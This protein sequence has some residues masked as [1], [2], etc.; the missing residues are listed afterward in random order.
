MKMRA[1][2]M[3]D[4]ASAALRVQ[5]IL[6]MQNFVCDTAGLDEDGVAVGKLYDHDIIIL[7][8]ST[9]SG[10]GYGLVQQFRAAGV[11]TPILVIAATDEIDLRVRCLGRGA[12][13]FLTKPYDR[14]ELVAH[15]RAV[16]RRANGHAQSE[17]RTGKLVINLDTQV[18]SVSDVPLPL[19]K[20]EY[21]V[22]ELLSLRKGVVVTKEAFLNHL[23]GGMDE[24]GMKIID[25]FICKLRRKLAEATGGRHYIKTVHG[26]GYTMCDPALRPPMAAVGGGLEP[27]IA[28]SPAHS[29]LA[30]QARGR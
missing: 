16:V 19:T 24:P 9:Q 3:A 10:A 26:R 2:I 7:D 20:K 12:D 28:T 27:Q 11:R 30:A 22:L 21:C 8:L 5:T 4:D 13:D 25:V 23:Y 29:T 14:R 15:V 6:A 18:A 17:I 1:F